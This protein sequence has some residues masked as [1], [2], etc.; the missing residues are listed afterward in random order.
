M[1][2]ERDT[3]RLPLESLRK[4][5]AEATGNAASFL[6][7]SEVA[8]D[9]N[10]LEVTFTVPDVDIPVVDVVVEGPDGRTDTTAA[11]LDKPSGLKVYGELLRVEYAGRD[12][13]TNEILVSVS[14]RRDEDWRT[15]LGCG[16]MWA[17]ETVQNGDSVSVRCHVGTPEA[18]INDESDSSAHPEG[19]DSDAAPADAEASSAE[20]DGLLDR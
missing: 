7:I 19:R 13:E 11:R 4:Q 5:V 12:S 1:P 6:E 14:Q 3:V 20:F 9:E 18:E 2:G 16:Q 8:I 17:V 15:I 10:A